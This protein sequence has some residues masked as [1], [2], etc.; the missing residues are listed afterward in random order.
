M[1]YLISALFIITSSVF[2]SSATAQENIPK[3]NE[4]IIAYVKSV[5]GTQVDRGE[6]WDLAAQALNRNNA[7]WDGMYVYGKEID[8]EKDE[9]FPGDIIQFKN[10]KVRYVKDMTI[11]NEEMKH[12]TAIVYTVI[13][14][15]VYEI[16]H[17]NTA[18]TGRKVG[19]SKLD[20]S[21]VQKGKLTFYRPKKENS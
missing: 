1:N 13:E 9:V 7:E 8:P 6:C 18:Y 17:Q 16:A 21:T 11:Y 3:L 12:H 4:Q 2:A 10:V 15:G 20:L 19:V 5:M 14:P